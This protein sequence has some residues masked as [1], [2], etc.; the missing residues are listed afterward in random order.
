MGGWRYRIFEFLETDGHSAIGNWL[1]R[2]KITARD[3]RLLRIKMDMLALN[4]VELLTGFVAGPIKSKL[5][6]R[7]P[8]HI[9]KLVIHGDVMLRPMFCRGPEDNDGEF[10]FLCGGV[11]TG[12]LLSP[13]SSEAERRLSALIV[14]P[15]KRVLNGRYK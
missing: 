15:T 6:P 5:H 8:S 11:E 3:R 1:D 13:D 2:D 4:G 9:Y 10:T 14:D 12:G 7:I